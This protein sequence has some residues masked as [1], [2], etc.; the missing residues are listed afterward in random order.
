VR[1]AQALLKHF[2]QTH[3]DRALAGTLVGE[4]SMVEAGQTAA[5]LA[6]T[7]VRVANACFALGGGA[8]VY[9]TSPLQR[10]LRDLHAA[11]QHATAHPRLYIAA[12]RLLLDDAATVRTLE[13]QSED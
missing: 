13:R 1:A 10:W 12:G 9:N 8:A 2:T 3:W 6:A 5:W 7:C 4:A 11:A